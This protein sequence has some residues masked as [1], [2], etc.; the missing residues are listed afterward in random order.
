M[1]LVI[2]L[3]TA[4]DPE[5]SIVPCL[6]SRIQTYNFLRTWNIRSLS[7]KSGYKRGNKW[8]LVFRYVCSTFMKYKWIPGYFIN[9]LTLSTFFIC[10]KSVCWLHLKWKNVY[11]ASKRVWAF[12]FFCGKWE[13]N[14][15]NISI[16][17]R[18]RDCA[19]ADLLDFYPALGHITLPF[20]IYFTYFYVWLRTV[21]VIC[22]LY[23]SYH[24]KAANSHSWQ[25]LLYRLCVSSKLVNT[26]RCL[27]TKVKYK[28][29]MNVKVSVY[30]TWKH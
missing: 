6:Q 16:S 18:K 2:K 27:F 20:Q 30:K 22:P 26:T 15:E 17:E 7:N 21:L 4:T 28:K 25:I 12:F 29:R 14:Y 8:N 3:S 23:I 5:H 11:N 13:W 19:S 10:N 24:Q 1:F 9:A